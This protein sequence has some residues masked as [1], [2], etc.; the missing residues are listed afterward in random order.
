MMQLYYVKND[1]Y[2]VSKGRVERFADHKA[3]PLVL[4]GDIEP[5]DE[6]K[7]A[8]APGSPAAATVDESKLQELDQQASRSTKKTR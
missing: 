1:L 5:Y 4:A 7:H 6:R 2:G 8:S 3:A